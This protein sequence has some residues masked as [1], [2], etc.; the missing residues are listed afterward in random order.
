MHAVAAGGS[1]RMHASGAG[2][3]GASPQTN[4]TALPVLESAVLV[5]PVVRVLPSVPVPAPAVVAVMAPDC[6]VVP[7]ALPP[8]AFPVDTEPVFSSLYTLGPQASNPRREPGRMTR[9]SMRRR[10]LQTDTGS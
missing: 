10:Y 1:H 8:L 5:P 6:A 3:Q 4:P 9:A 7:P 2:P